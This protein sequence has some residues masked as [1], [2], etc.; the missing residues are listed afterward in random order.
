MINLYQ[1]Y[2]KYPLTDQN[3]IGAFL[4]KSHA[5]QFARECQQ[6][7]KNG[8]VTIQES[9]VSTYGMTEE[10]RRELIQ[11]VNSVLKEGETE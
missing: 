6:L 5:E 4:V 2:R 10:T 11:A 7:C 9:H 8:V 1:V 3:V